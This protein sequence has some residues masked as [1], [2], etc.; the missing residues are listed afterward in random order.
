MQLDS[1]MW[2][3][4]TDNAENS[5]KFYKNYKSFSGN[6]GKMEGLDVQFKKKK[7]TLLLISHETTALNYKS[8]NIIDMSFRLNTDGK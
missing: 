5:N 2:L 7:H 4:A 1:V 3:K 6:S 8:S